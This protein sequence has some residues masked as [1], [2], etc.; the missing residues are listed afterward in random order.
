MIPLCFIALEDVHLVEVPLEQAMISHLV[1]DGVVLVEERDR[2]RA[3][4]ALLRFGHFREPTEV[5]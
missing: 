1:E 2:D 4:E 3:T 5:N